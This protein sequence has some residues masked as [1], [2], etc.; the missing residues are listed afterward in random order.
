VLDEDDTFSSRCNMS[1]VALEP[2]VEEES[3]SAR[4]YHHAGDMETK[5]LVEITQDLGRNDA[6][7]LHALISRHKAFTGSERAATILE[8]WNAY[9]PKFRKVMPVE[10]RRALAELEK[11]QAALQAAAE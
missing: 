2:V 1:M 5:G 3:I 11:E 6:E 9:L 10:Y 4:E 8:N 7:R